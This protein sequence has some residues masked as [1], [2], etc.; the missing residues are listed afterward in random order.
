MEN[1]KY[2]ARK[3]RSMDMLN[4]GVEP[5]KNG[6]N[7]YF[8]PSQTENKKY[9]VTIKD[10]WYSCECLDNKEGNLCKHILFLKTYFA[11]KLQNKEVKENVSI[12]KPCP[13]CESKNILKDGTRKT[14]FGKKQRWLC[15]DCGKRFVLDAIKKIKGNE[16]TIITAIDLYMKGVSYRGIADSIKQFYGLKVT[17]VTIMN[18]VNGYMEKINNY[19]NNNYK[20][21]VGQYWHADEQ[22]IKVKG[23][24]EYVWNVLDKKTKFLLASNESPKRDYESARETFQ[25]AKAIA[26]EPAKVIITDGAFSYNKAVSKE[27]RTLTNTNPHYQYVSLKSRDCSNNN[28]ER[29]HN[30]FRQRDKVMRGFKGNQ[31]QYAEN[32]KTYYN[33][34]RTHQGMGITPAQRAGIDVPNNWKELLSKSLSL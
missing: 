4:S 14:S 3:Q 15:S 9:K 28:I 34:V 13:H 27:F 31:K 11:I 7:E 33:F 2:Q 19:V 32:F 20:A 26:K 25:K 24:T 5:V 18:W 22:F 23:K 8:V 10:K 12:T 17:H 21:D 1:E 16:D 30:S 6:F 29:F